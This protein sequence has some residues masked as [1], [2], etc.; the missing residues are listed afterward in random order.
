[1]QF[2]SEGDIVHSENVLYNNFVEEIPEV[3]S[4]GKM[5]VGWYQDQSYTIP[6]HIGVAI[7]GNMTIYAKWVG[8]EIEDPSLSEQYVNS[9]NQVVLSIDMQG[10]VDW[11]QNG[12][13][14]TTT[15]VTTGKSVYV[16]NLEPG[17]ART[18][19]VRCEYYDSKTDTLQTSNTQIVEVKHYEPE[20]VLTS[21][22]EVTRNNFKFEILDSN[23]FNMDPLKF[24]WYIEVNG[25]TI[26]LNNQVEGIRLN[27]YKTELMLNAQ[28]NCVV[29]LKYN[30]EEVERYTIVPRYEITYITQVNNPEREVVERYSTITPSRVT[31]SEYI[32]A[33][34]YT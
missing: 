18:Y 3:T 28:E 7:T 10:Q 24:D 26:Q 19:Y 20:S 21:K 11:Y 23:A 15:N 17:V 34:W 14:M 25:N 27:E 16:L 31:R 2:N 13:Y 6:Y 30:N 5:F 32:F 1:M 8:L 22:T 29:Y 33:G 4:F 12:A 9:V